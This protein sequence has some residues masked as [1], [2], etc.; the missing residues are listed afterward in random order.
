MERKQKRGH[1]EAQE[2]SQHGSCLQRRTEEQ[3]KWR[4]VGKSR[5]ASR[6]EANT[7]GAGGAAT[8]GREEGGVLTDII[9]T[10]QAGPSDWRHYK[11]GPWA[12]LIR[13]TWT[14]MGW[15]RNA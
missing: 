10:Q 7:A 5:G 4:L 11:G 3:G 1:R 8:S 14:G 9:V 12:T 6:T 2:E 13:I 15:E